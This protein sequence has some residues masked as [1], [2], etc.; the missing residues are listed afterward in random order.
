M[1]VTAAQLQPGDVL[2]SRYLTQSGGM[3]MNPPAPIRIVA[4]VIHEEHGAVVVT[5]EDGFVVRVN[6]FNRSYC[7]N[8][9]RPGEEKVM[10]VVTHA[11]TLRVG[12]GLNVPNPRQFRD[13]M[14]RFYTATVREVTTMPDGTLSLRHEGGTWTGSP[15]D[16]VQAFQR[17][18]RPAGIV[19]YPLDL[20]DPA[21]TPEDLRHL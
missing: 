13:P 20:T 4:S 5:F 15:E 6:S 9:E 3:T 18:I 10:F 2:D 12:D 16:K 8:I 14:F 11:R 19:P 1:N 17:M 7:F 21:T